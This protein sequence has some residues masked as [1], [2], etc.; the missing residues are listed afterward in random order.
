MH[1]IYK[2]AAVEEGLTQEEI[3]SALLES[4]QGRNLKKVLILPPDYT[5][6]HSNAGFITSFYYHTLTDR[7]V[8]VEILPAL[9]MSRLPENSGRP[10]LETCPM[11]KCWSMTGGTT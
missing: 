3:Q 8:E 9:G 5:R 4:L 7:G 10:C 6:Y 2:I 1:D 11:R